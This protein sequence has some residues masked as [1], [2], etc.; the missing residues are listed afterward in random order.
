VKREELRWNGI[1]PGDAYVGIW[2]IVN[3]YRR[4]A[5]EVQ[6]GLS[7]P[8]IMPAT[9]HE[10]E[11]ERRYLMEQIIDIYSTILPFEKAK[12][13]AVTLTGIAHP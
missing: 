1:G 10:L 8:N 12:L 3:A 11:K 4:K 2:R 7:R 5:H 13:A 9:K 6:I